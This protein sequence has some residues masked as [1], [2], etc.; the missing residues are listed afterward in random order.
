MTHASPFSWLQS[1]L[2]SAPLPLSPPAWLVEEGQHRLVLLL[3]HVL[4]Q[5]REA[6]VRLARKKGSVIHVRW[7]GLLLPLALTPAG[8]LDRADM[9]RSPDLVLSLESQAPWDMARQMLQGQRPP[10]QIEG[11]V[12]LAAELAWLAD[13]LRWDV[14]EDLSRLIGDPAAHALTEAGRRL[15]VTVRAWVSRA[16]SPAADTVVDGGIRAGA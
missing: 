13:N 6:Q 3:N 15:L 8:L 4:M 16:P 2:Q 12:Q 1:V 14:E 10:V 7:G 5:E 11:D 9:Q